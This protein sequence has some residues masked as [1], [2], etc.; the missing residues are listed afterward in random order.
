MDRSCHFVTEY[1]NDENQ[2]AAINGKEFKIL[3][4]INDELYEVRLVKSEVERKEL[5]LVVFFLAVCWVGKVGVFFTK[6][7]QKLGITDKHEELELNA[8]SLHLAL[9]GKHFL[10]VFKNK[11]RQEW[12]LLLSKNCDHSFTA[13][14]C[15][16][17]FRCSQKTR[18]ERTWAVEGGS[19]KHWI[20]LFL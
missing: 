16:L 8:Y 11:K 5:I 2:Q 15:R 17:F 7:L 4:L 3:D 10:I 9:T 19:S 14:T 18:R 1:L 12:E 13:V 6:S 20:V